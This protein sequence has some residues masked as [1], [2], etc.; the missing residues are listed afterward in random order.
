MAFYGADTRAA[1]TA[2]LGRALYTFLAPNDD[3]S[4]NGYADAYFLAAASV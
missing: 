1:A 4:I 2:A 3:P